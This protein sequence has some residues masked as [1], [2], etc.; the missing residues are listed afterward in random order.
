MN[1]PSPVSHGRQGPGASRAPL[2]SPSRPSSCLPTAC[3]YPLSAGR[4]FLPE[5]STV[6][7]LGSPLRA[8]RKDPLHRILPHPRGE[9]PSLPDFPSGRAHAPV[10]QASS[11]PLKS[12]VHPAGVKLKGPAPGTVWWS[13]GGTRGREGAQRDAEGLAGATHRASTGHR[14]AAGGY[15]HGSPKQAM[16]GCTQ[17]KRGAECLIKGPS[18][19]PVLAYLRVQSPGAVKRSCPR[20]ALDPR[21]SQP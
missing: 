15:T 5:S 14:E 8:P 9:V 1:G 18:P 2:E 20:V 3:V 16:L 7:L 21:V 4:C 19:V 11:F 12:P 6:Q 10:L 13:P 17:G